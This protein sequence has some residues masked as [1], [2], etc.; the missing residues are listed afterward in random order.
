MDNKMG[1]FKAAQLRV[2][3]PEF[4]IPHNMG[5]EQDCGN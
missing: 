4:A 1:R 5:P 2:R 3:A